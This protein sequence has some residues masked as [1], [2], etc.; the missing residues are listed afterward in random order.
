MRCFVSCVSV[1]R[2]LCDLC[3]GSWWL[4]S[5]EPRRWRLFHVYPFLNM[6]GMNG[7]GHVMA[8]AHDEL[9]WCQL[10]L[11]VILWYW[12]ILSLCFTMFHNMSCVSTLRFQ[13]WSHPGHGF[14]PDPQVAGGSPRLKAEHLEVQ[15]S[16][17]VLPRSNAGKSTDVF[18][19]G[20]DIS[21]KLTK[22]IW[23]LDV[24][25]YVLM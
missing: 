3:E 17:L 4:S 19:S 24:W 11:T 15:D 12:L 23:Q 9:K 20:Q 21:T 6:N 14:A 7:I 1:K 8:M 25:L 5:R 18:L 16:S 10:F 22:A 13:T 2:L